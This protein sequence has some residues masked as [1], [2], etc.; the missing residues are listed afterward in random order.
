[1]SMSRLLFEQIIVF[2]NT[3]VIIQ[4]KTQSSLAKSSQSKFASS[5]AHLTLLVLTPQT[6]IQAII[7]TN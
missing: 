6:T 5:W 2:K 4:T 3:S 1:M 7:I